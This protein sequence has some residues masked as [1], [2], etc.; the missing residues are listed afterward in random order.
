MLIMPPE[1][2]CGCGLHVLRAGMRNTTCGAYLRVVAFVVV[3]VGC[4]LLGAGP[5]AFSGSRLIGSFPAELVPGRYQSIF[6]AL[7][8]DNLIAMHSLY[9]LHTPRVCSM[10]I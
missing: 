6:G 9:D 5:D 7:P 2:R 4:R 8:V 3:A 1:K 10:F